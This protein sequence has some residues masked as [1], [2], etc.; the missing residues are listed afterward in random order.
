MLRKKRF[1]W[2]GLV[3]VAAIGYLTVMGLQSSATYYYTPSEVVGQGN[4]IYGANVRVNGQVL[5]GS[6]TQ[7]AQGRVLK[8]TISD[9]TVT[10]PVVYQGVTPD[11]FKV[12]VDVV[13][14]GELDTSGTFQAH[15]LMPKC[16][17]RY[18]PT[19]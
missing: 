5:P 2:G 6:V 1:L 9:G 8:F 12:G 15:T 7:E 11:T 3:V 14:E 18:V 19:T 16:P 10:L 13:V 4:T 17:S